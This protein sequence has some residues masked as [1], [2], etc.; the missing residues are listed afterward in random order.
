MVTLLDLFSE[1]DQIKKWHQNLTDKKR[2]LILGLSTS[3]KALAIASSLEKED[4]IVL[5]TS[6]YGEAEGLVSD[7]ISILGEEL[8]YP[9]LVDDAPMVEFLMSSQEKIISRVEALRF[10]ID[11]S[12]KGILVC[13]IAASRLILPSPNAF[14]DSI[15]KISV[16]EE[17][18]QHAFIHQLKENGYRKVTQVQTQGEFSLRGDILDIFEISQ[19]EPCRIEFFGDE[20]DGIRSFEVETQLSKENKTELTIFP[21]SDMLLREKDYQRGQSALEKQISKTLSPILK[22]YLEEILSSFH[23]KQ[24]HADSRKFLSLCYDKT[25]TVFDYIE[26]DTPI[27]FDDYQKLMNQYEVFERELAQYFTEELQNSKA[28][29]DMQYF[30]DIEQIYKKQSPV[31]FFSNLQKG[32][33]NL[34]FDK[35]YQFNQYPMQEF[36]NQFSFLKEEIERYKKM[37]Y[38]IILQSSNS[39]GS[40]TL[41]DMLEEYQI[42]LDS[43]DKTSICKESVN[44]IEGN[45]RH[46]FHFVDEKILLITEHEIFQKKLKRRFRRQHVSNAE[47][48]KD[49]NELEKGD[50]VVHHIHGIGQYLGIE[51]IEIKEIHRDYVSVQYQNGDQI[52]IPVEQIHLLSKYISSDGKAPKLNKLNDGHFKKAK[53]KVKNQV[54]DIADDLIKLYSERSQLKGFAFSADDDDQDAFDDAFPYVETDDQLRSIEEIKRD[55]QASQ[56]M[57]RLLVGDVGFGKTEVAMRA[58]FKAVNDHKQVVILVPTTVLAQQHYTNF[59]ERFQ[60][61]AVNVDVLSRFRSKKEQTATLEKLKNGQV[62][63]LIGTHRVLSKDVVFADLGLMIIDEEQRFG[64]KHKETLKELKKQVDVLTLTATPIP[65]TLHMSMLGIRDLSVIETPPTNRYPVQT[66][67]LEK[68]DSVIRDAVLREMERGGQGYYLYNKVDTIVQKVSELQELIPEASIGYVHGRM[69]EVQLENTLLD[70]IEGQYDILVTTTIIETGVDIPNANTLFIENADHMG[71]STL[72]QLRG[73]VG[74]SNRIAYAYLMYRP[75]KSISEVSEKRLEAIKGFTELGSGFKIAMR[76]LSIRGAGNLLGK[77]QS[78][79]ID[80]VGFELYSQLLEEAIAKRNGNANANANTRTKGNAELILQ[81]DAYLPDTYISDQRHKIEIYKKIRQIDNRVNYEE[82]QEELIDR[83]GEYTDVVA[84]L[85]EIGLVK[86]YLDKVFVQRVERKDNKI[87]IQFEKVTQRLFL[88]QDYFKALSVTNLKAGIAENK[89]LMELVFD[90][91]NKKDYEILEGLLIFGES[92]LE[93][94]ES[95]EE[96]SI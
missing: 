71:L 82:L 50:Y 57:D 40:K 56:P 3:T 78:G 49:Y 11:S 51:T 91:Q 30:S 41:E 76:D 39:M 12:K 75:E 1:N 8:V 38:T 31:T 23:Q 46:G 44:L 80:S 53:Q 89:G 95:K 9:F 42:K 34:K 4:R 93:I 92:L 66:Y 64:V 67:V 84:Y 35:I 55:M 37:D 33:G 59:K 96:N 27:F 58:A 65:R 60:N 48:L 22:S 83:F 62:D 2:Q 73:R 77:S 28:F 36:F 13:N 90:V 19:L 25:W 29:S 68:N 18:D 26:K 94:K 5:L 87:T 24:S 79:F 63:I 85:L 74:R 54:E 7:L 72:Y 70:F 21:A 88:A 10:L 16:G 14:K 20:I 15:V 52:S 32:L 61:F 47:R 69:S 45:L 81:I 43:R 6:T 17:Y 86:S